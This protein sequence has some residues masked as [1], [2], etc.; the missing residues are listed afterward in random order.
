ML[1]LAY[2]LLYINRDQEDPYYKREG[3]QMKNNVMTLL[4]VKPLIILALVIAFKPTPQ[5]T[6]IDTLNEETQALRG[7][8][9]E[10]QSLKVIVTHRRIQHLKGQFLESSS[11]VIKLQKKPFVKMVK[12]FNLAIK[13]FEKLTKYKSKTWNSSRKKFI[14]LMKSVENQQI[15]LHQDLTH[16]KMVS[17]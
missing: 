7:Y 15:D 8:F 9:L 6:N 5:L 11:S 12:D 4:I 13:E 2:G 10:D 14:S 3:V 16:R 17:I 1:L